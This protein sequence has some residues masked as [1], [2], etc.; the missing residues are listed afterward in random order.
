[1]SRK[2]AYLSEMTRANVTRVNSQTNTIF[3]KPVTNA[4]PLGEHF[5][6]GVVITKREVEL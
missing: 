5:T 6:Y 2:K 3:F 1:M 4:F